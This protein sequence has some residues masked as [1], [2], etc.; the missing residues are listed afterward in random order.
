MPGGAIEQE[1]AHRG[2]C[3]SQCQ[4][5]Q[6]LRDGP[7]EAHGHTLF[8]I[9]DRVGM[10]FDTEDLLMLPATH[11]AVQVADLGK[12]DADQRD[13]PRSDSGRLDGDARSR[14]CA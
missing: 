3:C 13:L 5:E 11:D 2:A 14:T 9:G 7:N 10:Q 1:K 8:E 4:H 6:I 12:C